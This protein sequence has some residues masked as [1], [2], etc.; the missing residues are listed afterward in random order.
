LDRQVKARLIVGLAAGC[1][2]AAACQKAATSASDAPRP[3]ASA[4][5]AAGSDVSPGAP[6]PSL[7]VIERA[8]LARSTATIPNDALR[9]HDVRV[10]RAAARAFARILDVDRLDALTKGLADE[11]AEVVTWS[12]FGLG[13][14]CS[15]RQAETVR[16]LVARAASLDDAATGQGSALAAPLDA[17]ANALAR[18]ETDG[19]EQTLRAWLD[20]P[21]ARAES[22]ALALSRL[23]AKRH[24]LDDATVVALL[25]AAA[26]TDAVEGVLAPFG[27][28]LGLSDASKARLAEVAPRGIG[29]GGI[30]R[31]FAVRALS[32][33]GSH[34]VDALAALV[35]DD[36]APPNDRSAAAASLARLGKDG[37]SALGAAV[38]HA[39]PPGNG[40]DEHWLSSNFGLLTVALGSVDTPTKSTVQA[41]EKI[42][43][44]TVP[45]AARPDL[46]R[47]VV[48][49]RCAAAAALAGTASQSARLV[50]CDP[51]ER[52]RLGQLAMLRVLDRG[53]LTGPR[54]VLWKR[55]A[56]AKDPAVRRAALTTLPRHPEVTTIVDVLSES[57]G[58]KEPGVV[59]QAARV[60]A[61]EPRFA[62]GQA[63]PEPGAASTSPPAPRPELVAALAHAMEAERPPDEIETRIALTQAAGA[64]GVLSLKPRVERFCKSPNGALRL[65]AE[66]ALRALG[67]TN[68][69]CPPVIAQ[70]PA[71]PTVQ[72]ALTLTFVTDAGRLGMTIDPKLAPLTVERVLDLVRT[73]FYEGIAV[74]R[75]K[76]GFV[77]QFGD[78][79][80]DGSGGSGK[81]PLPNESSPLEFGP[82]TVGLALSGRDTGS[83]QLFVTLAPEPTLYGDYP[84]LGT[85]DSEW[86]NVAEGDVIRKVEVAP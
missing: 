61:D 38:E 20:G 60:I 53:A 49:L 65:S 40:V 43:E 2:F 74:H 81:A 57:L 24:R 76:P 62:S 80:G 42:A 68:A 50:H 25:D 10:R 9:D 77:V 30:A 12:S 71:T 6:P 1:V 64:V 82:R 84:V 35:M 63:A 41:L 46:Q 78:P 44:L 11:D 37:A 23:A 21:K 29:K 16:A 3:V 47:R 27:G 70:S 66:S 15:G 32:A 48:A 28:L 73:G 72:S 5:T 33:S 13:A 54:F 83:S 69:A 86:A 59:A 75:V 39:A 19:A 7:A 31:N 8:E 51:D 67:T 56:V 36:R 26:R 79:I 34:G 52:G 22:A 85:A 4:P 58:A 18:C 17:I 45:D 14:T 55:L